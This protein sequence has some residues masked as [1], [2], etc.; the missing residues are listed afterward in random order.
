MDP[1]L[2]ILEDIICQSIFSFGKA[3]VEQ[4]NILDSMF[5]KVS[6]LTIYH[7]TTPTAPMVMMFRYGIRVIGFS[8]ISRPTSRRPEILGRRDI[9]LRV[10][11]PT[12]GF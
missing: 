4:L 1:Y 12:I 10:H 6:L 5:N 11:N 8:V 7:I 9:H 3:T 2:R